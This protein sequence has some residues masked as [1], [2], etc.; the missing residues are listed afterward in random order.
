MICIWSSWCHCH[1]IISCSSKIQNSLP[2]W[3]QFT[4]VVLEK[5]PLNG[6][7]SFR[8][9]HTYNVESHY[10]HNVSEWVSQSVSTVQFRLLKQKCFDNSS[11]TQSCSVHPYSATCAEKTLPRFKSFAKWIA[12][13]SSQISTFKI[14]SLYFKSNC[15]MCSN[16]DLNPNRNWYLPIT[17]L[18][19]C[20]SVF[21]I[22]DDVIAAHN[23]TTAGSTNDSNDS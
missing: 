9:N 5:R 8:H 12:N 6:C 14:K 18:Q 22:Q 10:M 7:S 16:H 21:A 1:L 4:R 23:A 11:C 2:F 19:P 13:T 3:C 15:Q 20:S 17:V